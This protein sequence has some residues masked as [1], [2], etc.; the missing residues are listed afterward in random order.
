[1]RDVRHKTDADDG[2][3]LVVQRGQTRR[4]LDV[5]HH[6]AAY[7]R[8]HCKITKL[9]FGRV[10]SGVTNHTAEHRNACEDA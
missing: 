4:L 8:D 1:M 9:V 5:R 6:T 10:T 7:R 2:D 3:G